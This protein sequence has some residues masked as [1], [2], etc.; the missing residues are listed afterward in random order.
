MEWRFELLGGVTVYCG[1]QRL[2]NLDLEGKKS[3]ALLALLALSPGRLRPREEAIDLIWP[4]VDFDEARNRFKQHL[5]V[6]RKQ[7]ELSGFETS[8]V[9]VASRT[10][11]GIASGHK[12][13]V[14]QFEQYLRNAAMA[15]EPLVRAQHL[16]TALALYQGEF[17]PGFYLDVL[18]TERERLAE[19][20]RNAHER[21]AALEATQTT[22]APLPAVSVVL[23]QPVRTQNRFFGRRQE[24]EHLAQLLE[25]NR[26]VTLLGPGGT[27]KTRLA[28]ELCEPLG[29]RFVA[30]SALRNGA[31]IPDAIVTALSL[32]D[33]NETALARLQTAFLDKPMLLVLDN[34][35][36]LVASG[37]AEALAAVLEEIPTLR[38]LV[39]SR[40]KLDLPQEC[41]C[42]LTPLPEE[43][44]VALF[45]N[46]AQLAKSDFVL[47]E[48]NTKTVRELCRRLDGLPLAI[49]L[50][51]ARSAVLLP[52]QILER[53]SRRFDLLADKRCDREERHTSLRAALDWGWALLAPDVQSFFSQL[54]VFR[55]SFSLEAAEAVTG[56]FLAI[57]YL[58]SLADASF[59]VLEGDQFRL[60]ETL[61]EYGAE[62]LDKDESAALN[63]RH[64]AFY[65]EKAIAWDAQCRGAGYSGAMAAFKQDQSNLVAAFDYTLAYDPLHAPDICRPAAH[66]WDNS[67]QCQVALPYLKRTLEVV[68][69]FDLPPGRWAM[70]HG[71]LGSACEQLHDYPSAGFHHRASLDYDE[72]AIRQL[73]ESGAPP[74]QLQR[75]YKGRAGSFH[76]CSNIC[77]YE[78][79]LEEAVQYYRQAMAINREQGNH[80]WLSFNLNT[81]TQ[82]LIKHAYATSDLAKRDALLEEGATYT[83]EAIA[84]CRGTQQDNMLCWMLSLGGQ[85][86]LGLERELPAQEL[87]QEAFPLAC[88]LEEWSP[89]IVLLYDYHHLALLRQDWE[90]ATQ[91][92]GAA[93]GTNDRWTQ[94]I[95]EG[96]P[97]HLNRTDAL[98]KSLPERLGQERYELLYQAGYQAS[99]DALQVLV[100]QF[101]TPT[102]LPQ[103]QALA[104]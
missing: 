3:G 25:T 50:A 53:L 14:A 87:M 7:L 85:V 83:Q 6:L 96:S 82:V 1:E 93:Y 36:Q 81:L 8:N 71:L 90:A 9:L 95:V 33:S 62:K 17:A 26:L 46:R 89:L 70:L 16:R 19:L 22:E 15:T 44:A 99:L 24:R 74:E 88:T 41:V 31:S 40:I 86:L 38:L 103:P 100:A 49:E 66:L 69:G 30:L 47:T 23:P 60:L 39:T 102:R 43:D 76:N 92:L 55:G 35:E 61:R 77:Y 20:A 2:N 79:Q 97:S 63:R 5:A 37:G 32:P 13:D 72:Q 45:V 101:H 27:G 56:E 65:R 84:L 75:A 34:V 42:N 64:G 78:N 28:E 58:Q 57:D 59:L 51:A 104:Y 67:Y 73:E 68:Q 21:L 52:Q 18:L 94:Q 48:S 80:L 54:C 4:E 12:S 29:A 10:H 11:V 91:F 98:R